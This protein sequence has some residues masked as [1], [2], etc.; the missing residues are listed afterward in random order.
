MGLFMG[1]FMGLWGFVIAAAG[2]V[3]AFYAVAMVVDPLRRV[4]SNK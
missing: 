3:I 2:V 1:L 4:I